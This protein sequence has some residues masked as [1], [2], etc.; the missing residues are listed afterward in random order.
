MGGKR[1]KKSLNPNDSSNSP[2][3]KK[4]K[5]NSNVSVRPSASLT[6]SVVQSDRVSNRF[7]IL[8]NAEDDQESART[9]TTSAKQKMKLPPLVVKSIPLDKIKRTMQAIGVDAVYQITRMGI[10]IITS[11]REEYNISKTYLTKANIPYF[12]HDVASEKPFKAVIRGLPV[13]DEKDILSELRNKFKLQALAVFPMSRRNKEILYCN[14]LY[15][16]HFAKNTASLR[17]L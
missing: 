14:C 16:I 15:L 17:A 11:T 3:Q 9:I 2:D 10:K 12:T 5:R 7:A 6:D 1:K 8:A 4:G 13:M